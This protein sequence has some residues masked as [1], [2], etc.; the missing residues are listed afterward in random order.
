MRGSL[1]S[2]LLLEQSNILWDGGYLLD[3][4]KMRIQHPGKP[5]INI[6]K[7]ILKNAYLVMI[8]RST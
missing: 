7:Q 5:I 2:K 8:D 1:P 6:G 3:P 4:K